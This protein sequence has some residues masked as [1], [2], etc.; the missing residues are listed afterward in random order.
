MG[1]F[2]KA[3]PLY[4]YPKASDFSSFFRFCCAASGRFAQKYLPL[5]K[6]GCG[7]AIF[8]QARAIKFT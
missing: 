3:R 8:V 4:F 2:P 1:I 5:H 6:I 7:S